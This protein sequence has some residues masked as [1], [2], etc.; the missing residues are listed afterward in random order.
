MRPARDGRSEKTVYRTPFARR[1]NTRKDE[2]GERM[3]VSGRGGGHLTTHKSR[4]NFK[5]WTLSGAPNR[6]P[7]VKT[8]A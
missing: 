4:S 7:Q 6:V 1:T 3:T 2:R 5:E 8:P